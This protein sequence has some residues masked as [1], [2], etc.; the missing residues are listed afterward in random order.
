MSLALVLAALTLSPR[1]VYTAPTKA[2]HARYAVILVL[3]G[4]RPGYFGLARMPNLRSLERQ[5][6]MYSRAFVGQEVANTP[7]SHATIGTGLFPKHTGVQG[8]IWRDPTTGQAVRPADTQPVLQGALEKVLSTHH[9]HSLAGQLKQA[10]TSARVVS[11]SGHKCY[12]AD[13]MGT[14]SADYILCSLIYHD[15]WVAQAVG[16]HRPPPG[17]INNSAFDVPIPNPHSGFAP[18]VEQWNLGAENAWTVRYALWAFQRV[19]YPRLLMVNLPET[20]VTGHFA[21]NVPAVEGTLIRE[22]DVELGRIVAAYKRAHIFNQTVFVVTADHGMSP[23]STRIPFSFLDQS[24]TQA[25][26]TKVFDEGDTGASIGITSVSKAKAVAEKLL[27]SARANNYPVDAAYYKVHNG[28]KWTYR[29]EGTNGPLSGALRRAYLMLADTTA[30]AEGPDVLVDYAPHVTT[31]DRPVQQY[32]WI[33]GHLG[34]GWD[35]QHIPLII[36]GAGVPHGRVSRYPARLVDIA[37][38]L[39]RLLGLRI[40]AVD[41]LVLADAVTGAVPGEQARQGKEARYLGPL[42]DALAKRSH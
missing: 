39:E 13:A 31:G 37:P 15:R 1:S 32:H 35:E 40:P 2:G 29:E 17:A 5:G 23:I 22:F 21:T 14:P 10:D 20:D 28:G 4:A 30:C 12:A 6:V 11:A 25:G 19:H 33:G 41:G 16:N 27:S 36:S 9:V 18:A 7:P 24:I 38:T 42:V 26:A 34:A 8:F 3:D